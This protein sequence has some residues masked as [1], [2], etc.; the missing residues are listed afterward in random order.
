M[1]H[2]VLVFA[3]VFAV[4]AAAPGADT[5]LIFVRSLA[6]GPRAAAPLAAGITAAKLIMLAAAAAGVVA[7]AALGPMFVALKIAGA[8]YLI[9]LGVRMW[10]RLLSGPSPVVGAAPK[11]RPVCAAATGLA[12]G[13]SNPQAIVFYVALLLAVINPGAGAG[14]YA[15]LAVVLCAAMAV[16]ATVYIALGSRARRAV[17][18]PTARRRVTALL[19]HCWSARVSWWPPGEPSS[20]DTA[21]DALAT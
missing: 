19:A 9:W 20:R 16:V 3:G 5:M 4:S 6:A 21:A 1:I 10:W 2:E 11:V 18:S 17:S 8:A 7:A 14:L 13:M 12:L 15:A